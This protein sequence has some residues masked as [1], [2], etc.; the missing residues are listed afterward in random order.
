MNTAVL[1][2]KSRLSR[3]A[4]LAALA[5]CAAACRTLPPPETTNTIGM[6]FVLI[7][8]GR[9]EMGCGEGDSFCLPDER[10][11]HP[12]KIT[13]PFYLG[14]H[15]VTQE[16]WRAL[17]GNAP[18]VFGGDRRPVENVSWR[19][20][21]EFIRRLNVQENTNRY[22]LPTEAEWEYA[23]RAATLTRFPFDPS[24]AAE[25]AWYWDDARGETHDVG[26]MRPNPWG[27]YDMHGN[28]WEWVWD[29]YGEG[30]Y[31]AGAP[32][33]TLDPKGP[34]EGAGRV[35]RGGSWSND[36]R[37]LRSSHRNVHAPDY[38]S[39]TAGFRVLYLL[40]EPKPGEEAKAVEARASEAKPSETKLKL[41]EAPDIKVPEIKMPELKMPELKV[42]ELK[43]PKLPW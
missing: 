11:R 15:E 39:D 2:S 18:A 16:Q 24:Q 7:K 43:T 1:R 5:L 36:L 9:F 30:V 22:R 41:P 17:I 19:E 6:E 28:V 12:V 14:K 10:P 27:L 35:L 21:Q 23:A 26:Q 32:A 34:P 13:R 38:K 4:A 42:P 37:Y 29:W 33:G 40:E 8:A 25:F 31:A 3:T 20:A